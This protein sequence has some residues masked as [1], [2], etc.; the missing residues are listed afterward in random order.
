LREAALRHVSRYAATQA[1]LLRVLD[2]RIDRWLKAARESSPDRDELV[3]EAANARLAAR[4]VVGA[5]AASRIVDDAAYAA[6]R[7]KALL[8][9]G[10][11]RVRT[12]QH[13]AVRGIDADTI[14]AAL[15]EDQARELAA[16]L[17][18][19]RKRRLGA[20]AP[21]ESTDD[22]VVRQ[23]AQGILARAG[24]S[25]DV[26]RRA[27]ATAVDDAEAAIDALRRS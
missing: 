9:A 21:A 4:R 2:R 14:R 10:R 16:A 24:F 19:T 8:R 17:L 5:L 18:L 6:S 12:A 11:S 15:P 3:Q 20:F 25:H 7:G 26:A 23:R 22:A 27:L 13:L 1:Q